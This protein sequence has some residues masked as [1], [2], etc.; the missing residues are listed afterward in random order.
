MQIRKRKADAIGI[1]FDD[2]TEPL[3]GGT[4]GGPTLHPI[5]LEGD[6]DE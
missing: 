6:F 3:T 4:Y 5:H 2:R 1:S